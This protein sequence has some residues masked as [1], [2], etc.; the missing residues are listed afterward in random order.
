MHAE[1]GVGQL[2]QT[3]DVTAVQLACTRH[4]LEFF[5]HKVSYRSRRTR[6]QALLKIVSGE[7]PREIAA[8]ILGRRGEREYTEDLLE[9]ALS[10]SELPTADRRLCQELVYGIVRWQAA[11]DWLIARKTA[12][13][14]QKPGLRNLLRLGLYQ[15]FWLERIPDHAAV[16]ET[17]ELAKRLGFGPQAGFVNA[18]LRGYLREFESTRK[19]LEELKRSQPDVGYSH[20]DWLVRRWQTAWGIDKAAE[21]MAWN[22]SPSRTFARVNTLKIEPAKLLPLWREEDVDYDFVRRDWLEENLVF[23][24][25]THPPLPRLAS[26]QKGFFYIQ[27]P[28]TLLAVL[29]LAPQPDET[30][31]D[32]CAAPG[33]KLTYTA[34]SMR[35]Q[36]RLFAVDNNQGRLNFLADNCVRLGV[37]IAEPVFSDATKL[38]KERFP[39]FDRILLD[40]P[41]S[42]SGVM[43]RRV[44]L[45]WRISLEEI[46]RLKETQLRLIRRAASLLKPGGTLVYSTCSLESEENRLVIDEALTELFGLT[47]ERERQLMP[48]SEHVDGAYV[49]RLKRG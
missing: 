11:L 19:L 14:P 41:C 38:T 23:E 45:R 4:F 21:L 17:V 6:G 30:I 13:R 12:E 18:V 48:F 29:E 49:A 33:G 20:P 35:N 47:L 37:T 26:F 46:L 32:L 5:S 31:L 39:P 22:N 15:I 44:D 28:S 27:D 24:L 16:N 7:K 42:N 2:D 10:E 1:A 8:Q 36:G 43:R 9:Q 40:A 25:K 34:Q 3:I